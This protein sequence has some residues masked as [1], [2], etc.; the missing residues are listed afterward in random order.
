MGWLLA[1]CRSALASHG[2]SYQPTGY[3]IDVHDVAVNGTNTPVLTTDE[4]RRRIVRTDD[5]HFARVGSG[6]DA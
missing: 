2:V 3:Y 4:S 6:D 1:V 5:E